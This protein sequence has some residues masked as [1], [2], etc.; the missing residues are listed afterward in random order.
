MECAQNWHNWP[1]WRGLVEISVQLLTLLAEQSQNFLR[2]KDY[3]LCQGYRTYH[4]RRNRC[5][6]LYR[7]IMLEKVDSPLFP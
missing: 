4:R 1:G 7:R 3:E 5:L 6:N 2:A